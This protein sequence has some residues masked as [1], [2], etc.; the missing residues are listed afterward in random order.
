MREFE[1]R[2]GDRPRIIVEYSDLLPYSVFVELGRSSVQSWDISGGMVFET[3]PQYVDN[4]KKIL[5]GAMFKEK[6]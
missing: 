5:V 6:V 2:Q 4:C 1:V 3:L